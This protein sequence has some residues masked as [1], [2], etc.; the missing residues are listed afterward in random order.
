MTLDSAR[1]QL[2]RLAD[3]AANGEATRADAD[4]FRAAYKLATRVI[5]AQAASRRHHQNS[6]KFARNQVLKDLSF[7]SE[8]PEVASVANAVAEALTE[9]KLCVATL[10]P[11]KEEPVS[12]PAPPAPPAV[13]EHTFEAGIEKRPLVH[14]YAAA[15][16]AGGG[17][18]E[19]P[20]ERPVKR[21]SSA[22][23]TPYHP[24]VV[25]QCLQSSSSD[26]E[27]GEAYS[28]DEGATGQ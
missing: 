17:G 28:S 23:H 8:N 10:F 27:E 4:A 21:Q 16:A 25:R 2:E 19:Q 18:A 11:I 24:S 13:E 3:C 12:P 26:D 6:S 20:E 22:G 7:L 9:A 14:L 1:Q 15:A 5:F